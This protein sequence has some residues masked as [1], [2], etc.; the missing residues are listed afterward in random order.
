MSLLN[1]F[2]ENHFSFSPIPTPDLAILVDKTIFIH[3]LSF[4][5]NA[6]F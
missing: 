5:Q 1:V 4:C 6:E 2:I 3:F